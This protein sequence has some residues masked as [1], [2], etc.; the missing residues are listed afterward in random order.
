MLKRLALG[1]GFLFVLGLTLPLN[2]ADS[3][4]GVSVSDVLYQVDSNTADFDNLY[5]N[6]ETTVTVEDA[7]GASSTLPTSGMEYWV[8]Y[9]DDGDRK[10]K[11]FNHGPY[12]F[13]YLINI[14]NLSVQALTMGGDV[15]TVDLPDEMKQAISDLLD[16]LAGTG[17]NVD[18]AEEDLQRLPEADAVS[19]VGAPNGALSEGQVDA[20]G[21]VETPAEA[22]HTRDRRSLKS[23][24]PGLFSAFSGEPKARKFRRRLKPWHAKR[25]RALKIIP[26]P[27]NTQ[28]R[29][30]QEAGDSYGWGERD[31][32]MA[33]GL[34]LGERTYDNGGRLR[35]QSKVLRSHIREDGVSVPE[36]AQ[37]LIVKQDGDK[38]LSRIRFKANRVNQQLSKDERRLVIPEEMK[39]KE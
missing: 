10:I 24:K 5:M 30:A 22:A 35:R 13:M 20:K 14:S 31:V 29:K 21:S 6:M 16:G 7:A 26:K 3:A 11:F 9:D 37:A 1:C 17:G 33:S 34:V 38:K 32:D 19:A 25:Q 18:P 28:Q 8:F 15:K 39:T 36:E 23:R 2:A 27:G 4:D 12:P